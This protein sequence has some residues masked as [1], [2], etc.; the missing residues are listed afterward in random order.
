MGD[1]DYFLALLEFS[2]EQA[3]QYSLAWFWVMWKE[4]TV[5]YFKVFS[6]HLPGAT[7]EKLQ[8]IRWDN[9]YLG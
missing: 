1:F 6:Q 7:E 4:T 5:S 9:Q 3:P 2:T 8:S